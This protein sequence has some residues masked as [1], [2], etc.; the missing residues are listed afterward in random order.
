MQ[1]MNAIFSIKDEFLIVGA[2]L[3]QDF[4]LHEDIFMKL[5]LSKFM[6]SSFD[7]GPLD[8]FPYLLSAITSSP[9]FLMILALKLSALAY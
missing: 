2:I 1:R 3:H 5:N 7:I 4:F 6:V 9:H 8:T